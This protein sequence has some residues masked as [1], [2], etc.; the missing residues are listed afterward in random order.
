MLIELV[1]N[2]TNLQS[3]LTTAIVK[4]CSSTAELAVEPSIELTIKHCLLFVTELDR[5]ANTTVTLSILKYNYYY[6]F[7]VRA[8][9]LL[10]QA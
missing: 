6:N 2:A 3:V 5:E 9:A 4:Y 10:G 7:I 8:A 1:V